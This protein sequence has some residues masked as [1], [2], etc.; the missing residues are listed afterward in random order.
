MIIRETDSIVANLAK[1][2]LDSQQKITLSEIK[3]KDIPNF[4]KNFFDRESEKWIREESSMFLSS[5]RF[6]YDLPEVRKKFDELYEVLKNTAI[7]NRAKML[8]ILE[9]GVKLQTNFLIQPQRTMV[10]FVYRDDDVITPAEVM[11]SM[12]Y[13]VDYEYYYK[14]LEQYFQNNPMESISRAK[15]KNFIQ[16]LDEKAIGQNKTHAAINVAKV[17]VGFLNLGRDPQ[18]SL[19]EPEVLV[20][21]Y[22]D[23]NLTEYTAAIKSLTSKKPTPIDIN[24]LDTIFKTYF[25]GGEAETTEVIEEF[26]KTEDLTKRI[27]PIEEAIPAVTYEEKKEIVSTDNLSSLV[28]QIEE[29]VEEPVEE[30][31][32]SFFEEEEEDIEL[33]PPPAPPVKEAAPPVKEEKAPPKVEEKKPVE[34]AAPKEKVPSVADLFAEHMAKQMGQATVLEDIYTL[35]DDRDK[36]LYIKKLFK[37]KDKEFFNL[38]NEI[39]TAKTWKDANTIIED[40]FYNLEI[41]PYQKEA[42][43]FTDAVYTRYFPKEK[44]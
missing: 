39:N 31:V 44:E 9:Q 40:T 14:G 42:I 22:Q 33:P 28:S 4:I 16:Q 2:I 17:I 18:T 37:K 35:I 27:T 10:Q 7:F 1:K 12:K 29:F 15:F 13:F 36:K 19:V 3:Q 20:G 41:N 23:R 11:D 38:L 6:N 25:E 43:A 24:Q 34:E 5:G 8:R 21:A 26:I 30:S 32:D